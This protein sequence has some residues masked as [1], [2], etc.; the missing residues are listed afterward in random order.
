MW[1]RG[2]GKTLIHKMWIIC[3]FLFFN[4]SL[5]G[6][7]WT[8]SS[9]NIKIGHAI[10]LIRKIGHP[11]SHLTAFPLTSQLFTQLS[12]PSSWRKS[13]LFIDSQGRRA[14]IGI[15]VIYCHEETSHGFGIFCEIHK[16]MWALCRW[17]FQDI[18]C[19]SH[20]D[21]NRIWFI[22]PLGTW[23]KSPI[24]SKQAGW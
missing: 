22:S 2:G 13:G 1:I 23:N 8:I 4:P 6:P 24:F 17:V 21:C 12:I 15:Y 14:S 7:L 18:K 19:A 20:K 11:Y 9:K 3:R 10:A 5:S 16:N